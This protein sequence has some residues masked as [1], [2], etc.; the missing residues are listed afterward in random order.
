MS[1]YGCQY[2]DTINENGATMTLQEYVNMQNTIIEVL[3]ESTDIDDLFT[4]NFDYGYLNEGANIEYTK[5]FKEGKKAYRD[6]MKLAKKALKDGNY[7]ECS[8]YLKKADKAVTEIEKVIRSVDSTVGSAVFGL[9]A[10]GLCNTFEMLLPNLLYSVGSNIA[11]NSAIKM[12]MSAFQGE[13]SKSAMAGSVLGGVAAS[14]GAIWALIKGVTIAIKDIKQLI[15]EIKSD[16][17]LNNNL[18]FYRNKLLRYCKDLH[19]NINKF[20]SKIKNAK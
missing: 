9:F 20:E 18:N 8:Q 2:N 19:T 3:S 4:E 5:A 10:N 11:A 16:D 17:N 13:I 12:T 1:I 14:A 15:T 6:N 7:S